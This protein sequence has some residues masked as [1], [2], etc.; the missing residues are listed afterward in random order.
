[1]GSAAAPSYSFTGDS[2][3][4]V[5]MARDRSAASSSPEAKT[6]RHW[7]FPHSSGGPHCGVCDS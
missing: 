5:W 3:T 2:N 6:T 1:L 7:G 4:G